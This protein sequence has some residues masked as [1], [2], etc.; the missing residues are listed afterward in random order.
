MTVTTPEIATAVLNTEAQH[1]GTRSRL[2]RNPFVVVIVRRLILA[3]PLLLGVSFL[4]FVLVSL[5]PGNAAKSILGIQFNTTE[6]R[7][8]QK[9]LGLNLPIYQQYWHWLV[10]AVHG[11]L[12]TSISTGQSVAQ[13]I[14]Q[15][16]PVTLSLVIGATLVAAVIGTS[17]GIFS[18][19]RQGV[20]GRAV[21]ALAMIGFAVPA[22]WLG[23]ELIVIFAVKL[24]W[25]PAT[26]Y[27][28]FAQSPLQ[29]FRSLVLPVIALSLSSVAGV[30]KMTRDAMLDVLNSEH[31]RAS[32]AAGLS[33]RSIIF[34]HV[35]KNA[36]PSIVTFV[37]LQA[38]L[39]LGGTVLVENVFSLP[40][41]GSLAVS[42]VT[43]HDLPV[44]E[45]VAVCYTALVIIFNTI[46]D[47]AYVWF[48]PNA[49]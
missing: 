37:G 19:L 13:A 14:S 4:A 18:A 45:G 33:E 2:T 8:L 35:F 48:T 41:L 10:H 5:T 27:V 15:R 46:V 20:S 36:S 29:W 34:R 6:Y 21:D 17:I 7:Q 39:M 9:A 24:H 32:R 23:A 16:L 25:L 44:I 28:S 22:F 12:G 1:A 30:G 40:G 3:V 38:V 26:G 31:V 47:L 11:N 49:I 43:S 42:A